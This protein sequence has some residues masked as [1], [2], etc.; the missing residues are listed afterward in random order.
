M[1]N[2]NL[3]S[4]CTSPYISA[5]SSPQHF[6]STFFFSVPT[7]PSLISALS[8]ETNVIH[9]NDD[10]IDDDTNDFTFEFGRYEMEKSSVTA[11]DELFDSGKIRPK[12]ILSFE[13]K[14]KRKEVESI[15]EDNE[16]GNDD[17][18]ERERNQHS[19]LNSSGP[20]RH[21][22]TRSF[23]PLRVANL[24]LIEENEENIKR[25]KT[26]IESSVSSLISLWAR[27]WKL[28]DLLLFRSASE[29]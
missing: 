15:A 17:G 27:T 26:K 5:P 29:S 20:R 24:L 25:G 3:D 2:F 9:D 6:G 10:A 13:S 11:T 4:A 23:S 18:R 12:L 8:I 16:L 22:A 1:T 19:K 28:K 21:K 7:S 14:Q